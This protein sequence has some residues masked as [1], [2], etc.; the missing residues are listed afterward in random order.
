MQNAWTKT[1]TWDEVLPPQLERK[2]KKWFGEL[3]DLAKIKILRCL[4]DS[5]SKEEGL[6]VHT[7]T[8]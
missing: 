6:T 4:K 2:W 8:T 1:V 3:P 7:F 5:H